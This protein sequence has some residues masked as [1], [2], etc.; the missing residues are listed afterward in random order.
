M[1][2]ADADGLAKKNTNL[3]GVE[4][5][6]KFGIRITNRS[7][8]GIESREGFRVYLCDEKPVIAY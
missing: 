5:N 6:G 1:T 8:D 3:F 4:M 2:D 7:D